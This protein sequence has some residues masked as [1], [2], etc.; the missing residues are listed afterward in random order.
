VGSAKGWGR[1]KAGG[2]VALDW[3]KKA[4]RR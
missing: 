1:L 4:Q 2:W 3:V